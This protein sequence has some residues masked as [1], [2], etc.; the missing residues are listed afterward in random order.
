MLSSGDIDITF[1]T[2]L[3]CASVMPGKDEALMAAFGDVETTLAQVFGSFSGE[4]IG[5][6]PLESRWT[7]SDSTPSL[8]FDGMTLSLHDHAAFSSHWTSSMATTSQ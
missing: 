1:L 5:R 2:A 3:L 8:L 4:P 7:I 6:S